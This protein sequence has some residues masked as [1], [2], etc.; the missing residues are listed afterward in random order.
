MQNNPLVTICI[1]TYN[2]EKFIKE[3]IE[4][5]LAQTYS[6][7]ELVISDD[8][9]TDNTLNII[10]S[11][12][13]KSNIPILLFRHIPAGLGSNWN[14]CVKCS[15]GKYIK[16]LF[17][18]DL[19]T[20]NCIEKMIGLALKDDKI[21]LVFSTRDIFFEEENPA[22]NFT[23]RRF[24]CLHLNWSNLKMINIGSSLLKD[25]NFLKPP[26][27]KIGEPTAVLLKKEAFGKAGYFSEELNQLLDLE[28]W[29]RVFKYYK[30]GF[31]DENLVRIRLHQ[32][33]SGRLNLD[34]YQKDYKLINKLFF[35]NLFFYLNPMVQLKILMINTISYKLLKKIFKR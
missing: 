35:K 2:G 7:I 3:S 14:N 21:G 9:S 15:N 28:Y 25:R 26:L 12:K 17:Q 8:N 27:N 5:A 20:S 18:D 32:N 16:F 11:Y 13:E 1:P 33:Q 30:V 24:G 10:Q 6:N 4:S 22:F 29:Y 34:A 31:I 19:L 23:K